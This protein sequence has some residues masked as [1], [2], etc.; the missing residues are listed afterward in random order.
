MGGQAARGTR[1]LVS[2]AEYGDNRWYRSTL[3]YALASALLLWMALPPLNLWPLA[4]IAPLGWLLLIRAKH[5]PGSATGSASAAPGSETALAKLVAHSKAALAEPVARI[6]PH[7]ALLSLAAI[8]LFSTWLAVNGWFLAQQYRDYWMAEVLFWPAAFVLLVLAARRAQRH[9]YFVLWL[10]GVTFWLAAYHWLR[11]PHWATGVGWLALSAYFGVYLPLFIG[12]TRV[13]VHR[14][15]VP[16]I[17]AAPVVWIGLD[18]V[19]AHLLTGM[20]M[21]ALAHTQYRWVELIQISDLGGD[22]AVSFLVMFVAAAFAQAIPVG[23]RRWQ[24]WPLPVAAVVLAAVLAYGYYRTSSR[25]TPSGV[26][27]ALIQGCIDTQMQHDESARVTMLRHYLDLTANAVPSAE[28]RDCPDSRRAPS[29]HQREALVGDGRRSGSTKM[30]LSPSVE[31][32][33]GKINLIVWPESMFTETPLSYDEDAAPPPGYNDLSRAELLD[34]LRRVAQRRREAMTELAGYFGTPLLLGVDRQHLGRDGIRYYNS[35]VCV[36]PQ[37]DMLG[38]YDK[39]HLVTF[40]EYVPF[41]KTFPWL[42]RL[43]PLSVSV[44]AGDRPS[45]FE[46]GGLRFAPNICFESVLSHAI[47]RQVNLLEREGREPDVLIN[48]TNDG[49]F[50]GSSELEMHL[51]CGV[52]RAVECRK[53]LLIAAN[54]GISGWIDG[55]G[56][57]RDRAPRHTTAVVVAE[58]AADGRQSP[59]LRYGDWPAGLCLTACAAFAAVGLWRRN[60]RGD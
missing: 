24:L 10:V 48:L 47:R 5:L 3:G 19:R 6:R 15:R 29:G 54:T 42:H 43:T 7:I 30:G 12:L 40:G 23:G 41:A 46:V 20:S 56:R 36:T 59:Y 52:F 35:A 53:P 4:W 1:K 38:A 57:I 13:A 22:Y 11:L 26:R 58:V 8:G 18:L 51:A 50:W 44:T 27:V 17:L 39:M 34:G 33:A 25:Q 60:R 28:Q 9:P 49:W 32:Q 45:S 14:R 16:L 21:G 31:S 37:G 2:V 55:D